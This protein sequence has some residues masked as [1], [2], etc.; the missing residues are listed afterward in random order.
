[1]AAGVNGNRKLQLRVSSPKII[2]NSISFARSDTVNA[3]ETV[4]VVFNHQRVNAIHHYQQ[5]VANI[6]LDHALNIAHVIHKIV[7]RIRSIS[8]KSNVPNRTTIISTLSVWIVMSNGCQN[9]VNHHMMSANC[10]VV[11]SNQTIIS[12]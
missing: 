4:A 7:Q 10:S 5:M 9:M 3:V 12:C 11:S 2:Y 8:V 6:A 1:M